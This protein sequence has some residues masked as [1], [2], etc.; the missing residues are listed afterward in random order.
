MTEQKKLP[1]Y[2]LKLTNREDF[3]QLMKGEY[4][5]L[6]DNNLRI[7]IWYNLYDFKNKMYLDSVRELLNTKEL[8]LVSK[9]TKDFCTTY[10]MYK[11]FFK[12]RLAEDFS[13]YCVYDLKGKRLNYN[14]SLY[15]SPVIA[16]QRTI[17]DIKEVF[18]K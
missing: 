17:D 10:T 14:K 11:K 9:K 1:R 6:D 2:H 4:L 18:A 15:V 13:R 3:I 5:I 8:F 7:A 16:P 12:I